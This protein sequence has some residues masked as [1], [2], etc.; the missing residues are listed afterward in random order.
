MRTSELDYELDESLIAVRPAE[1]RE[2]ARLMV[3]RRS[4]PQ[5]VEHARIADLPDVLASGDVLVFNRT[6]VL[7][8]RFE[9]RNLDTQGRV[10]GLWLRD[11]VG[12]DG[13]AW[14][15]L[16]RARRF[17]PG[18]RL[19]LTTCA[20]RASGV[21]LTLVEKMSADGAWLVRVDD[22]QAR[23]TPEILEEVGRT[24]IPPYIRGARK[25]AGLEVSDELDRAAYQTVFAR[26][27]G[28]EP[29]QGSVA[30]PTAGLHFTPAL[31]ERIGARGV[32]RA[33]VTLHVGAGTFKPIET[34][35]VEEHPMHA[36]WCALGDAAW[37]MQ[38]DRRV[39]AVGSTSARTLE[40]FA[41]RAEEGQSVSGWVST[42]LLIT[43]GYRW[44]RVDGLLTNFHLPRSTLLAMVA[45]FVPGGIERLLELYRIA[46]D[47][48]YRFYSYGDAMLILP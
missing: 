39:V 31:L 42:E 8:A 5:R 15:A 1:P 33:E 35:R 4:D 10:E 40:T 29:V 23:T 12:C 32:D 6:R 25:R 45:A 17:R 30:A 46:M 34:E 44:R 48:R 38:S 11:G 47:K 13:L 20:A 2:S 28:D 19:E 36:E 41:A 26:E 7:P 3:V 27:G 43:P 16:V 21:I 14:E 37:V 18:R 24:P 9:G 22:P